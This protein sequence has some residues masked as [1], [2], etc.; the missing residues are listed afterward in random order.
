MQAPPVPSSAPGLLRRVLQRRSAQVALCILALLALTAL[1]ADVLANSR[2]IWCRY[3]GQTQWPVFQPLRSDSI[4]VPGAAHYLQFNYRDADW[5]RLPLEAV[6]WAPVPYSPRAQDPYNRDFTP[7]DGPQVFVNAAG[8]TVALP[9]RFRH[10][11]GSTRNGED[12]LSGLIHGARRSLWIGIAAAGLAVL[13]GVFFGAASG[14]FGDSRLL[15]RRGVWITIGFSVPLAWFY[16]YYVWREAWQNA[17]QA[18]GITLWLQLLQ[19]LGLAAAVL[20]L[21]AWAAGRLFR[22]G[23]AGALISLPLDSLTGRLIELLRSVPVLM[24]IV[25]LSLVLQS[26]SG[27]VIVIFGL[28]AWTGVARLLRAEVLRIRDA[29]FVEAARAMGYGNWRILSRHV[30]PNCLA[31]VI[32][33]LAFG[34]G[35]AIMIEAGLSFLGLGVDVKT[36][37]WGKLLNLGR[38]NFSAWWLT[39][40]PALML[41]LTTLSF[42]LLGE[43]LQEVLSGR[44][45]V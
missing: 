16:G 12:L 7:P 42:N 35:N 32:V 24:L 28:T 5:R 34:I 27:T 13:I 4:R 8:E 19:S 1:L 10:H 31:P 41:F 43:R 23:R 3:N 15:I 18:G 39:L 17:L 40:F 25:L 36:V 38:S 22:K 44:E 45:S 9:W 29:G 26:G 33:T 14:Y 6:V 2:P 20:L 30:V 11:L 37:T 21:P